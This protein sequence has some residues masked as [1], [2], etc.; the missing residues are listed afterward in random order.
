V[1]KTI[2][3]KG[4]RR[5]SGGPEGSTT[6]T[7]VALDYE[8]IPQYGIKIIAGRNFEKQFPGDNKRVIIN[9]SLS[10]V[11]GYKEPKLAI[12]EL[13]ST[14]RDTLEII[15]VVEDYHQM[16]LKAKMIPLTFKLMPASTF[17]S[18]KLETE[19][20]RQVIEALEQPWKTF[21]PGNPIDYFFL[22]Q[23]F[24]K[25]YQRGRSFWTGVYTL[26]HAGDLH[27]ISWVTGISVIHGVTTNP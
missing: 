20:Y 23:F 5:L 26:H 22:D 27:C 10:K 2:G 21:F 9:Q 12:G 15:G 4:I 17:Y 13:V 19:N 11:L 18:I 8:H 1:K 24:N 6:V 14:G 25:Q 16:S 3:R 7:N